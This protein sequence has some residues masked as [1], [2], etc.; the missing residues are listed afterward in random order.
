MVDWLISYL[1]DQLPDIDLF[2]NSLNFTSLNVPLVWLCW[3]NYYLPFDTFIT[4]CGTIFVV[5]IVGAVV[6][7][8][9]DLL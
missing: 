9:V 1:V 5:F 3:V 6:R 8:L 4:C 7:V 2:S